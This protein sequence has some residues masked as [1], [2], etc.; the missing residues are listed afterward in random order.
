MA[1]LFFFFVVLLTS[2]QPS[3]Q[4]QNI[5]QHLSQPTSLKQKLA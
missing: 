3:S 4:L 2:Q 5:Q 1:P